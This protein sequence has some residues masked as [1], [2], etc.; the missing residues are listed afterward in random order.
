MARSVCTTATQ[1]WCLLTPS[2]TQTLATVAL[3]LGRRGPWHYVHYGWLPALG[4]V[5]WTRWSVRCLGVWAR[6]VP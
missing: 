2:L 4:R 6:C 3:V 1:L 5:R